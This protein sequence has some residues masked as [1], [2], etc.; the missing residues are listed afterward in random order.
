M[1]TP[2][3]TTFYPLVWDVVRQVPYGVVSTYG[4]IAA[5]IP[6]PDGIDPEDYRRLGPKWVGQALNAV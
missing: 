5:T 3:P 2:D 1:Q 6:A 4:Q